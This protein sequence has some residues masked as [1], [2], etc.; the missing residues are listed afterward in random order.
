MDALV[1]ILVPIYNVSKHIEKC[2][3]SLFEQS[4]ENIEYVFVNDC[5]PDNSIEILKST[6]KYYPQREAQIKIISHT[7]NKGLAETR[8]T[9]LLNATGEYITHVDSDDFIELDMIELMIKKAAENDADMILCNANEVHTNTKKKLYNNF[10]ADKDKYLKLL[11]ERDTLVTIW[12]RLIKR[13]LL[14]SN[15]IFSIGGLNF[16]EDYVTVPRI[17]FYSK[18]IVKVEKNLYN[19]VKCN[20]NS[21]THNIKNESLDDIIKAN[22]ILVDFFRDKDISFSFGKF[23]LINKISMIYL[24]LPCQYE[25]I[26]KFCSNVD[27]MSQNISLLHKCILKILEKK[28]YTMLYWFINFIK[29]IKP[30]Y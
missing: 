21:Y 10:Y 15:K 27:Y 11:L 9:A 14:V 6:I 3:V 25:N 24:A 28:L 16:G 7:V 4:Y 20:T 30:I 29:F 17:V 8:N 2:L 19:Y 13:E 26:S 12:G 22:N 18:K 5:S 23:Q 1:S